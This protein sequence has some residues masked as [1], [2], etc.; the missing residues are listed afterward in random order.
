MFETASRTER[1]TFEAM[2]RAG[3]A[4]RAAAPG[5]DPHRHQARVFLQPAVAGLRAGRDAPALRLAY[6]ARIVGST[7]PG[8]IVP[9]GHS[10]DRLRLRQRKPAAS[11]CCLRPYR[12]AVAPRHLW[13]L[14][15]SSWRTAATAVPSSG[16][17]T[18]GLLAQCEAWTAPL[19]WSRQPDDGWQVFTLNGVQP[20]E[21]RTN[22]SCMSASTRRPPTPH[23]RASGC[24]PSSSGKQ[25]RWHSRSRGTFSI[26]CGRTPSLPPPAAASRNSTATPGSGPVR[27]TSPIPGS[28]P[29]RVR[30]PNTTA[31]SCADKWCCAAVRRRHRKA[32]SGRR[33]RNFFPPAARWQFSGIRLAEDA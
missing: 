23:G 21:A 16:C 33:Y 8:G 24:R 5:T 12:L 22:P 3:A 10:S 18:A 9:I 13:R 30:P 6:A 27:P 26:R 31:S 11:S 14:P 2:V 20:L 28:G 32:I 25:P 19:Y 17:P 7:M 29:S 4:P 15:R 1:A